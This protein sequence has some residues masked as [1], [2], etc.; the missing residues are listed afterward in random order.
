LENFPDR[1]ALFDLST[2]EMQRDGTETP[3]FVEVRG[4]ASPRVRTVRAVSEDGT[5]LAESTITNGVYWIDLPHGDNAT[6][7]VALDSRG[8]PIETIPR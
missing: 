1:D 4:I 2:I 8:L 7:L 6:R 5:V 3:H